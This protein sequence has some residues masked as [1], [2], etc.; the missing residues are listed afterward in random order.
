MSEVM[1]VPR[2]R[3]LLVSHLRRCCQNAVCFSQAGVIG[4]GALPAELNQ[5]YVPR[6]RGLSSYQ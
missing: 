1:Y 3:G 6:W 4:A 5:Q 2:S